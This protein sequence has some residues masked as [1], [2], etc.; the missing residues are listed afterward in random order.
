MNIST[1]DMVYVCELAKQL[2]FGRAAQACHTSQPNLSV[3]IKKV[4]SE[5]GAALFERS[6]RA[7]WVT[8]KG[9]LVISI[10]TQLLAQ[11][12]DLESSCKE[13]KKEIRI[14]IFPTLAP[15]L[16][17]KILPQLKTKLPDITVYIVEDKTNIIIEKLRSGELDC[18][19]A[20][21][22]IDTKHLDYTLLFKDPFYLAVST[23]NP[24]ATKNKVGLDDIQT[25][26]LMIL[27]EGHCLRDQALEFCFS[28]TFSIDKSYEAASL[29]T[30]RAL[31][32]T[33]NGVTLIPELCL[34]T[35]IHINYIPFKE[36]IS[37]TIGLFWRQ[38]T[39]FPEDFNKLCKLIKR[40]N[41]NRT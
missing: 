41:K 8:K 29:E 24:L 26:H 35:N 31:V 30:I 17:P 11:L 5:L 1:Q 28:D 40:I 39:P 9:E 22:P 14:G 20:A 4:E 10:F 13:E 6:N 7:V 16:I 32:A 27:E 37:R 18:I 15:Y 23:N 33:D 12:K 25:E 3:Q 2:H 36:P 34:D 21:H 19:L 38:S